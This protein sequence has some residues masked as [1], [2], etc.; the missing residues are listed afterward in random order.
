V[1]LA[2]QEKDTDTERGDQLLC[3]GAFRFPT[4][5]CK[6]QFKFIKL[7]INYDSND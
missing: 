6:K 3:G 1:I 4:R 7:P 2:S 5:A